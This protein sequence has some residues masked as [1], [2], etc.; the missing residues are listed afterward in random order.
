MN[1]KQRS[2]RYCVNSG[3]KKEKITLNSQHFVRDT[4]KPRKQGA[5]KMEKSDDSSSNDSEPP[6][7]TL[8]KPEDYVALQ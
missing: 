8:K 7:E 5:T 6:K 2:F 3:R 1:I 4:S